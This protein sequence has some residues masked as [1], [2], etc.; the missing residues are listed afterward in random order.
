MLRSPPLVLGVIVWFLFGTAYS[1]QVGTQIA[2]LYNIFEQPLYAHAQTHNTHKNIMLLLHSSDYFFPMFQL[3]FLRW[4]GN[5]FLAAIS[6]MFLNGLLQQFPY[7]IHI[8][9]HK[10]WDFFFPF[11]WGIIWSH[12]WCLVNRRIMR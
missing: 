11:F 5:S 1:V 9:V 4:K 6:I 7:F 8:Q 12:K 2:I 3:P 10:I